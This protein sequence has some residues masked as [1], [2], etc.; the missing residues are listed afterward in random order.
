MNSRRVL[1]S[2]L[3]V[4]S[5][6]LGCEGLLDIHDSQGAGDTDAGGFDASS[7]DVADARDAATDGDA[8][9]AGDAR[10]VI[11]A[12]PLPLDKLV[13]WLESDQGV[14]SEGGRITAWRDQ[15]PAHADAV[16]S[17][18]TAPATGLGTR[19]GL[20]IVSFDRPQC[21]LSVAPGFADFTAGLTSFVVTRPTAVQTVTATGGFSARFLDFGPNI[22]QYDG[23]NFNRSGLKVVADE[24]AY[25]A[26]KGSTPA[27]QIITTTG[28]VTEGAWQVFSVV[29]GAGAGRAPCPVSLYKNGDVVGAG[30]SMVPTVVERKINLIGRSKYN[31]IPDGSPSDPDYQGDFAEIILYARA[32]DEAERVSVEEYLE[33]KWAI[34]LAAID[35]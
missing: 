35:P 32:L 14:E 24:I 21:F 22:S 15:S 17:S 31:L 1:V 8:S 25:D 6:V 28:V 34:G 29:A 23:V 9:D 11:D 3:A 33:K 27:T 20:P 19:N 18:D 26:F 16:A 30:T 13:L 10:D 2:T 7:P 5:I 12:G 4:S